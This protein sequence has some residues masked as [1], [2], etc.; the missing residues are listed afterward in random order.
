MKQDVMPKVSLIGA[1]PGS[2]DL[3]WRNRICRIFRNSC[4][5]S[6]GNFKCVGSTVEPGIIVIGNV[7][8]EHPSFFEEEVQR[9]LHS[10]L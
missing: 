8:A 2:K 5:C 9:V 1:G 4:Y 6:S 10:A 3:A 7:V